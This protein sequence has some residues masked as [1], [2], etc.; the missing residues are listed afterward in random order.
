VLK[1]NQILP[2]V[3]TLFSS[4]TRGKFRSDTR[5]RTRAPRAAPAPAPAQRYA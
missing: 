3:L 5:S 4:V 2:A 1:V